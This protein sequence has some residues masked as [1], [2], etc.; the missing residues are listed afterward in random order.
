MD[1]LNS[2]AVFVSAVEKGSLAAAAEKFKISATMAG[3]HL[4]MLERHLGVRLL[5][6]T[7][8]RQSLTEPGKLYFERCKLVLADVQAAEDCATELQES[9]KGT[10]RVTAPVSFGTRRLTPALTKFLSAHPDLKIELALNDRV[11]DLVEE[12]FDAAIRIGALADSG[13][14]AR[15]LADYRSRVC[16][17]PAYL[18][19]HGTP[20]K[21]EDLEKHQCMGFAFWTHQSRW[22]FT[23]KGKPHVAN[24][25]SRLQINN[26]EA[27]RQAALSG[28]GI[29][30]QP[31]VLLDEDVKAGRLVAL[32][33]N[34][35]APA[36]PMHLVYLPDRR[37]TAK[38][39]KFIEFV[40]ATFARKSG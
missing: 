30:M 36:R 18:K 9:P 1:R 26:G 7:T 5:N 10:L 11:V 25:T 17:A 13:L 37:P 3:K 21:P 22:R 8:R 33:P 34:Y 12:G 28:F 4:Q 40:L 20:R 38:M 35:E 39:Q 14:I 32:L 16:A 24:I 19:R 31:E 6:R 15:P 27:L 2:M 23:Q 29:I